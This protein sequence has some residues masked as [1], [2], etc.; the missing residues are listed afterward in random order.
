M[1]DEPMCQSDEVKELS[2]SLLFFFNHESIAMRVPLYTV[3]LNPGET[4]L[5]QA[6]MRKFFIDDFTRRPPVSE[7]TKRSGRDDRARYFDDFRRYLEVSDIDQSLL[8]KLMAARECLAT[9]IEMATAQ[10]PAKREMNHR[11]HSH[12]PFL[13]VSAIAQPW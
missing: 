6:R 8:Q 12:G 2:E 7:E 10:S 5:W 9:S 13:L 4:T 11:E 1:T 3:K